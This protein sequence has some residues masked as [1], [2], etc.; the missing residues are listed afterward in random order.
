MRDLRFSDTVRRVIQLQPAAT[1]QLAPVVLYERD[2][3]R[4]K[5]GSRMVRPFERVVHR[6]AKSSHAQAAKYL[7]R[8]ERSN[9]KKRDGW[10]RDFN[11][12]IIRA[13]QAGQKPLRWDRWISF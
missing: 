12:N 3:P 2:A 6:M 4:R 8:H 9:E 10:V 1:G 13:V 7:A 5:K 11:V